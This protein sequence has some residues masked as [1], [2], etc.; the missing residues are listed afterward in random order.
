[1][2]ASSGPDGVARTTRQ[3]ES[4]SDSF[5][6]FRSDRLIPPYLSKLDSRE[7]R[8]KVWELASWSTNLQDKMISV[9][10]ASVF[11]MCSTNRDP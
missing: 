6:A 3:L 7:G 2:P 1:M 11:L 8:L 4:V 5:V 9:T 10:S